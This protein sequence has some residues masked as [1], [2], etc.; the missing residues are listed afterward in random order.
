MSYAVFSRTRTWSTHCKLGASAFLLMIA[1]SSH[2]TGSC[3]SGRGSFS[4]P[5]AEPKVVKVSTTRDGEKTRF[6]VDNQEFCEVT[7]TFE[8]GLVNLQ[9]TT[10][11]PYTATFPARQ[12]TEAFELSPVNTNEQ[13][14]YRYTNYYKLGSNTARHDDSFRYQLPYASGRSFRVTQSYGGSF[15]HKGSNK[16]AI[17]WDMPQGTP[18]YAARG[19]L[20][21]KTRDDSNRG[22]SSI[23]YDAYNNFVLIRHEDGTLGH[24]CHLQKGGCKVRAGQKVKPGDLIALSG[25]TGFSSGPHLHFCVFK[26]TNGRERAS[27]PIKFIA[28]EGEGLTLLTGR[29][30]KALQAPST[31]ARSSNGAAEQSDSLVQ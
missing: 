4:A 29:N 1:F 14:E 18:V 21:V 16:Y 9:G 12:V 7:M 30:Y 24:Y 22:G 27:I 3:G 8:M 20:V 17:D 25:N 28:A 11:F 26:T 2:L 10:G 6:F 19:G 23:K 13:W 15:S 5:P 31:M